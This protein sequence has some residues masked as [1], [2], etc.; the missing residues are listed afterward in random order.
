MA[1]WINTLQGGIDLPADA[2]FALDSALLKFPTR[3]I[4]L[5]EII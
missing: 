5:N 2:A 3:S 4:L 1:M